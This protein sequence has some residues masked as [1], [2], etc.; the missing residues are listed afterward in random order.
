MSI[1]ATKVGM[2][3][4]SFVINCIAIAVLCYFKSYKRFVFRLVLCLMTT[5]ILEVLVQILEL[6]P[7]NH[8][9][10]HVAVR[11]GWESVC[12][13]FGFLDQVT[14]WMSNFCY[15]LAGH[16]YVQ[17]HERRQTPGI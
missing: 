11:D 7:V 15:H 5:H 8:K 9:S 1:F 16:V 14:I 12:A 17:A 6:V 13:A 2:L 4:I 10:E 3:S